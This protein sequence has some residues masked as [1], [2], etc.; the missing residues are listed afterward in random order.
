RRGPMTFASPLLLWGLLLIPLALGAYVLAQRRRARYAVRFTNLDLLA[1]LIPRTAGWRRHVPA[2]L[3]LAALAALLLSLARPR[4]MVPVPKEQA[5]VVMVLDTSGSMAATD[6][7]PSRMAAAQQAGKS[8]LDVLP[9]KFRVAVVSF[10][11]VTQTLLRPTTDRR[12]A[13]EALDSLRADGGT[14]MGDGLLRGLQL[15]ELSLPAGAGQ[16]GQPGQPGAPRL[17]GAPGTPT[18]VP[19]PT[20]Q[21]TPQPGATPSDPERLPAAILLLSDGASTSGATQPLQAARTAQEMGVPVY[22]IAL[23]TPGGTVNIMGRRLAVPPD[24]RTL[25]QIAEITGGQYFAAPSARDLE[26]V[27]RDIGSRIGYI[28]EPREVTSFFAGAGA[29][30]LAAGGALSLVWLNRFP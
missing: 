28:E 9:P 11:S 27:Y 1:N 6:V 14:A 17:P 7:Q 2:L 26:A 21:P 20:P 30:L 22:A 25:R 23:G 16:P 13:R 18:P 19:S 5:T 4:M 12:A 10:N 29:V 24:E 15:T 3:Y 8:F